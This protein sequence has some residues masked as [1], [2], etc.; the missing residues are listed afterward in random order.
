MPSKAMLVHDALAEYVDFEACWHSQWQRLD[1]EKLDATFVAFL[2]CITRMP[3]NFRQDILAETAITKRN[4]Q[5]QQLQSLE[6]DC[7][8]RDYLPVAAYFDRR[9]HAVVRLQRRREIEDLYPEELEDTRH[10]SPQCDAAPAVQKVRRDSVEHVDYTWFVPSQKPADTCIPTTEEQKL[11]MQVDLFCEFWQLVEHAKNDF[12]TGNMWDG[13]HL[14]SLYEDV[15]GIVA[16]MGVCPYFINLSSD[17]VCVGSRAACFV[18]VPADLRALAGSAVHVWIDTHSMDKIPAWIGEFRSL[19]TLHVRCSRDRANQAIVSLPDA[20]W[21]MCGLEQ[22]V[23]SNLGSLGVLSNSL[24]VLSGGTAH[25]PALHT[26]RV[27]CILMAD[28]LSTYAGLSAACTLANLKVLFLFNCDF[29]TMPDEF[30]QLLALQTLELCNCRLLVSLP[31]SISRIPGLTSL[32]LRNQYEIMATDNMFRGYVSLRSLVL[33]HMTCICENHNM[34]PASIGGLNSLRDLK[35]CDL[36]NMR[37]FPPGFCRLSTLSKLTISSMP[38]FTTFPTDME[39]LLSLKRLHIHDCWKLTE[40]PEGIVRLPRLECLQLQQLDKLTHIAANIGQL[41]SLT[42]LSV[43]NCSEFVAVP[44]GICMLTRLI[45]L[46]MD[47]KETHPSLH[48]TNQHVHKVLPVDLQRQQQE[49]LESIGNISNL[50]L[51]RLSADFSEFPGSYRRLVSLQHLNLQVISYRNYP[52]LRDANVFRKLSKC[53]T[54][55]P[56]LRQVVISHVIASSNHVPA[57]LGGE[58][59]DKVF[60]VL[61]SLRAWPRPLLER[62]KIYLNDFRH[63]ATR[64]GAQHWTARQPGGFGLIAPT[65][66]TD[67][68]IGHAMRQNQTNAFVFMQGFHT[69]LGQNSLVRMLDESL[70]EM[71]VDNIMFRNEYHNL[72]QDLSDM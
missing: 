54:C 51:L 45:C 62:C 13:T 69:R 31:R 16:K 46:R 59:Q 3:H 63:G 37:A 25:M 4:M 56:A 26:L 9:V 29:E 47:L 22:L 32:T 42:D 19:K 7:Y 17:G 50:T 10:D 6:N 21:N 28:T 71:I 36:D 49:N 1:A 41:V 5:L 27:D 48:D 15:I 8:G 40:L 66:T 65:D 33:C 35:L 53:L 18:E 34:L 43:E 11:E 38:Q 20:L 67:S 64:F 14:Y 39:T 70:C 58:M 61:F 68:Y 30:D 57:V 23:L 72:V 12:L 2:Q 44:A 55:M 24:S 60:G 52:H